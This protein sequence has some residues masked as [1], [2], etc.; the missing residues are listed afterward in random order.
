MQ[1]VQTCYL[2]KSILGNAVTQ[3][4]KA[5]TLMTY[6]DKIELDN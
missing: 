5:E 6:P 2:V 1:N 4:D 3:A